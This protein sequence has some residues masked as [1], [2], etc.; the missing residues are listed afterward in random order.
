M[1][2]RHV[3]RKVERKGFPITEFRPPTSN[4]G[5]KRDAKLIDD[6]FERSGLGPKGERV[7]HR[8]RGVRIIGHIGDTDIIV[9]DNNNETG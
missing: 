1:V 2:S 8:G 7:T 5:Q 6:A 4:N 9:F 3:E